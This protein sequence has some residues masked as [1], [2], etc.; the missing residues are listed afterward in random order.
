[1]K[2]KIILDTL[3]DVKNFTQAVSA[4]PVPVFITDGQGLRVS[5]KSI[6][7]ALYALEFN[8]LWCECEQ[9]IYHYISNF[10]AS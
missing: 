7:G 2:E 5:A 4:V 10:L 3:T 6:M 9:D 8:E 1:M